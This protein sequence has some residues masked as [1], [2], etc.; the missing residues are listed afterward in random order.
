MEELGLDFTS[1]TTT[2][3]LPVSESLPRSTCEVIPLLKT[4]P[5]KSESRDGA[6]HPCCV[7]IGE[8]QARRRDSS[9]RNSLLL[10]LCSLLTSLRSCLFY[11]S[12]IFK[13]PVPLFF[14]CLKS[15]SHSPVSSL[16]LFLTEYLTN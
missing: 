5:W 9:S 13:A 11:Y 6:G 16:R 2:G 15:V 7:S 10:H 14:S 1:V 4:S 8:Q 12:T 3:A